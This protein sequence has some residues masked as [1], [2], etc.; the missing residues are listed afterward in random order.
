MSVDGEV[1]MTRRLQH[2]APNLRFL[3]CDRV[4]DGRGAVTKDLVDSEQLQ[5]AAPAL[6][7]EFISFGEQM[8]KS[9]RGLEV[10]LPGEE[11]R[12]GQTWKARRPLPIDPTWRVLG[13][14]PSPIWGAAESEEVEVTFTYAGVRTVNGAAQAVLNLEGETVAQPGRATGARGRLTGTAVVDLATGQVIEE[15]VRAEA[16]VELVLSNLPVI[17]ARGT[18]LNRL[19][20][21]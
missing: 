10:A 4:V 5:S 20:R 11:V 15:E 3:A 14:L 18:V 8:I 6:Q 16:D 17:K 13:V 1:H 19:R 7:V 9:L 21:Q 12:P 2:V